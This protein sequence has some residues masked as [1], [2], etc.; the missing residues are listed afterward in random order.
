MGFTLRG[1]GRWRGENTHFEKDAARYSRPSDFGV[2]TMRKTGIYM[3]IFGVGSFLLP[4]FGLQFRVLSLFG[5]SLPYVGA[6]LTV[7][8]GLLVGLSYAAGNK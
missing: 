2:D 4:L 6:A 5:D 1:S 3:L 8:G 7:L